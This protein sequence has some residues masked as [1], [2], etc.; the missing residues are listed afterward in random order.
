MSLRENWNVIIS[1]CRLD[2]FAAVRFFFAGGS[3]FFSGRSGLCL[4]CLQC[5]SFYEA[6][7]ENERDRTGVKEVKEK[8]EESRSIS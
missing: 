2:I 8:I 6:T 3:F 5:L 1:V 4:D 7:K